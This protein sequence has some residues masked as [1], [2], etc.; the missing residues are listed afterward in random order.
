MEKHE[1]SEPKEAQSQKKCRF[2]GWCA[3]FI[4]WGFI[5]LFAAMLLGGLYFKAP[6]KILALDAVLLAL[7]TVV[8]QIR[9][10]DSRGG[11]A[12]RGG[13]DISPRKKLRRLET[14]YI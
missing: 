11:G 14:V 2:W 1:K 10:A 9:L 12:G 4:R 8:P 6:W 3:A 7:L 13:L 5:L